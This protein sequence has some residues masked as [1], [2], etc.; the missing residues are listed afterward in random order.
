MNMKNANTEI[1]LR[2]PELPMGSATVSES[3]RPEVLGNTSESGVTQL[4]TLQHKWMG[5]GNRMLW[6]CNFESYKNV[7]E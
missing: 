2:M 4:P 6:K 1:K 7:R 5:E 3:P